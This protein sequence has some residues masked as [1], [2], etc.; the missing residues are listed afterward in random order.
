MRDH[1]I[2]EAASA[3]WGELNR[4]LSSDHDLRF[5]RKGSISV[6]PDDGRWY[7]H[8]HGVGGVLRPERPRPAPRELWDGA[9]P[10]ARG[11]PGWQ[12]WVEARCCCV[13]PGLDLREHGLLWYQGRE[14]PGL[15][16]AVRQVGGALVAVHRTFVTHDGQKVDRRFLGHVAGA[17]VVIHDPGPYAVAD[18]LLVGEG[19]ESTASAAAE[20]PECVAWA[21]LSAGGM[22]TVA[23]PPGLTH[24][25]I[26]PDMD[27][28]ETGQHAAAVLMARAEARGV[29]V[30]IIAAEP[31]HNDFND[32]HRA[33]RR[34]SPW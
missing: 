3:R 17:H 13:F 33:S 7:D 26:A 24:L 22:R 29:R 15:V 20:R 28:A 16:A 32:Q 1:R 27:V 14:V 25:T 8:E 31:P 10:L 30:E 34:R 9:R 23:L 18:R 12:Y 4:R 5:G 11:R 21:A 2:S 19:L 6:R